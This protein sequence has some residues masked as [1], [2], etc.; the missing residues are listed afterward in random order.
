MARHFVTAV[1]LRTSRFFFSKQSL[2]QLQHEQNAKKIFTCYSVLQNKTALMQQHVADRPTKVNECA[3][4]GA[5]FAEAQ[6][7][8]YLA[9]VYR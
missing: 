1:N 6:T 9:S 2:R 5:N 4:Q 7:S 3:V 8:F